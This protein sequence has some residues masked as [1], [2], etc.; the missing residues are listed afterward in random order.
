MGGRQARRGRVGQVY[1]F[2]T[3]HHQRA[4]STCAGR[5]QWPATHLIWLL[6]YCPRVSLPS[7][8]AIDTRRSWLAARARR[9]MP[10][11]VLASEPPGLTCKAW[12]H[13]EVGVWRS[14]CG[15]W[16]ELAG[17]APV[18]LT[19]THNCMHACMQLPPRRDGARPQ[20]TPAHLRAA[21]HVVERLHNP[22]AL[23]DGH[24]PAAGRIVV[25]CKG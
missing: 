13:E 9:A 22:P 14:E 15:A 4:S 3:D 5:P 6:K 23:L 10:T 24:D 17:V 25:V 1:G 18:C 21:A 8:P 2:P 19:A 20:A 12:D 11:N 7:E 16:R